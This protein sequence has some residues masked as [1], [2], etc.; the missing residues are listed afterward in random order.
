MEALRASGEE[1]HIKV[2]ITAPVGR[3]QNLKRI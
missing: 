2:T 1:E 3:A